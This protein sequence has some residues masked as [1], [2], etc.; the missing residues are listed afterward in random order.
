MLQLVENLGRPSSWSKFSK[1]LDSLVMITMNYLLIRLTAF[2]DHF[3][4]YYEA[5]TD[6]LPFVINFVVGPKNEVKLPTLLQHP[7]DLYT[8]FF[9]VCF[10]E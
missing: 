2:V 3:S 5:N 7:K 8:A 4:A 9:L 1:S 6:S 10:Q